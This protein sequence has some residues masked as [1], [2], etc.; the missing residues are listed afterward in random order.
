VRGKIKWI[1]IMPNASNVMRDA[2]LENASMRRST[3]IGLVFIPSLLFLIS[4]IFG[5]VHHFTR[6]NLAGTLFY[7]FAMFGVMVVFVELLLV[8]FQH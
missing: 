6:S 1:I 3:K 5:V 7:Y 4:L 2:N 8:A